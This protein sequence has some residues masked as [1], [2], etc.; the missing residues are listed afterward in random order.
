MVKGGNGNVLISQVFLCAEAT[1]KRDDRYVYTYDKDKKRYEFYEVLRTLGNK[2][3]VRPI[4]TRRTDFHGLDDLPWHAVGA[5]A[6][7]CPED[8]AFW[9]SHFDGKAVRVNARTGK[10]IFAVSYAILRDS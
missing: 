10:Y 7:H 3:K 4:S 9:M 1:E 2:A 5:F 6:F 8:G